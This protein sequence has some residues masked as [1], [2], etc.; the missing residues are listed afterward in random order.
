MLL[1]K[2]INCMKAPFGDVSAREIRA[3]LS[4]SRDRLLRLLYSI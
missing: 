3:R 2:W 4:A 1:K